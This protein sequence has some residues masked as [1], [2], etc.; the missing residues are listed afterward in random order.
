[1]KAQSSKNR[2]QT[3]LISRLI[4]SISFPTIK[5]QHKATAFYLLVF[6]TLTF[7]TYRGLQSRW[8]LQNGDAAGYVDL[9]RPRGISE[10]SS[11]IYGN[12]FFQ[13]LEIIGLGPSA[14]R[15]ED[16]INTN[17]NFNIFNS[18]AYLLPYLVR[19]LN[20][21]LF[22]IESL[23]LGLLSFSYAAGITLLLKLGKSIGMNMIQLVCAV[24]ILLTSPIFYGSLTGQPYMD[25]LFF[26][27]CIAV[28]FL[29]SRDKHLTKNGFAG[30]LFLFS[31][32]ILISER[33]SLMIGVISMLQVAFK[34]R[35]PSNRKSQSYVLLLASI[36]ALSWYFIWNS[37]FNSTSYTAVITFEN[38][39]RNLFELIYGARQSN[40]QILFLCLLP[41]ALIG[42]FKMK[43]L[44][45][46]LIAIIPNLVLTIGGAELSGFLTHYHALYLPVICFMLF[47][48]APKPDKS[49]VRKLSTGIYVLSAAIGIFA[50]MSFVNQPNQR[51]VTL[52]NF[53]LSIQH[54]GNAL[55]ALP[56]KIQASREYLKNERFVVTNVNILDQAKRVS[57]PEGLMTVLTYSGIRDVDYFPIGLGDN[58]VVFVPYTDDSFKD[59]EIS[60]FGLVPEV[61]R[62]E[63]S[64][65]ISSILKEK[66]NLIQSYSG[67]LGN[68]AVYHLKD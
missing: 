36:I 40:F 21:S 24:G 44:L 33:A 39:Y 16:F 6:L 14:F 61:D 15:S 57:S 27:P 23:P 37:T 54:T 42:I 1:M 46:C 35:V 65:I 67:A 20:Q 51:V 9:F 48:A 43:Y 8:I 19:F 17:K 45:M 58:D 41:F 38:M 11:F 7:S 50:S 47:A 68:I 63:W 66:Y 59:V 60:L 62:G 30:I 2:Y 55:G 22:S 53:S 12:S 4:A 34:L 5:L 26:G 29:I 32:A 28:M 10:F 31:I 64:N 49:P 18:H 13:L 52:A 3:Q 25:R 56:S